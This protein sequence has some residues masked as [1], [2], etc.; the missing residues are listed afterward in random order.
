M[1]QVPADGTAPYVLAGDDEIARR[2]SGLGTKAVNLARMRLAG[3]PVP[4][5]AV[6]LP[7]ALTAHLRG[8]D[9]P[10]GD[11]GDARAQLRRALVR[12]P[13]PPDVARDVLVAYETISAGGSHLV[14][15]RSSSGAEDGGTSSYAGQF[16]SY[17]GVTP[18]L[19]LTRLRQC[20]ASAVGDRVAGYRA[21]RSPDGSASDG[22]A[23][24]DSAPDGSALDAMAVIVQRQVLADK[25]GV[26]FSR[27]PVRPGEDVRYLEANF[28]TAESV[29]GGL[30]VPDSHVVSRA[31]GAV[32]ESTVATKTAM[33]VVPADGQDTG[34][35][36]IPD[37]LADAPVL[38]GAEIG[39][40]VELAGR[41]EQLSGGPQD[42]EW[43]IEG[44]Q[45]WIVQARPI[46]A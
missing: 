40:L 38:T 18:D 46:T 28:G 45:V 14:A 19:L 37:F 3:I 6:V 29:V 25:G 33:T 22:S 23:L 1:D 17:L 32:L 2:R 34:E 42:I 26:L 11:P 36:P 13:V 8:V 43:A 41:I 20:W 7:A 5:L 10:T 16:E 27:H 30:S 4:P 44:D 21:G 12:S 24:E 15:V 9:R 31:T 39:A 35:I